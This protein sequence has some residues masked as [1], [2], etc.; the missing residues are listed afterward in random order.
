MSTVPH[1]DS[2]IFIMTLQ[3][4]NVLLAEDHKAMCPT[5]LASLRSQI[6][7]SKSPS[8]MADNWVS[9]WDRRPPNP[10]AVIDSA[11][12]YLK[13]NYYIDMFGLHDAY[14][15]GR[16]AIKQIT[17]L[18]IKGS[19]YLKISR[20]GKEIVVFKGRPGLRAKLSGTTYLKE[21]PIIKEMG[22]VVGKAEMLKEAG[23]GTKIAI[24]CVVAWD[25]VH[26]CLQD[27]FDMTR[28]EV[29]ILSDV[30]QALAATAIGTVVGLVVGSAM[31]VVATFCVVA[32]VS[33]IA[34]MG[35]T[36]LD[37][38]YHLT[39]KA[40]A[41]A[42]QIEGTYIDNAI[43]VTEQAI[44]STGEAFE[45]VGKDMTKYYAKNIKEYAHSIGSECKSLI[46]Y[47][48]VYFSY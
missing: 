4:F 12:S 16:S 43:T 24:V 20:S 3:Q 11:N 31:P 40:I 44:K 7:T 36:A 47:P 9:D 13:D 29:T 41:L 28:L 33:L 32:G 22:L 5:N 37:N 38:S 6:P 27:K 10:F 14:N 34:S 42:K 48:G 46:S 35:I 19:A 26:E 15:N 8:K 25:I 18:G 17:I 2:E 1:E 39:D 23:K 45:S 21:N 30:V